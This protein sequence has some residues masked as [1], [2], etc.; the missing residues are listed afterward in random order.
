MATGIIR[1]IT[2]K[3]VAVSVQRNDRTFQRELV[4]LPKHEGD[5]LGAE[6]EL[7]SGYTIIDFMVWDKT[8]ECMVVA[9]TADGKTNLKTLTWD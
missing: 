8:A 7:E 1:K 4:Y 3:S 2:D 9:T 6:I 5:T